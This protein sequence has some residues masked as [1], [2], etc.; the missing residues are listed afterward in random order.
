MKLDFKAFKEEL[1]LHH[2][3]SI[4]YD[5]WKFITKRYFIRYNTSIYH[6]VGYSLD[7]LH[8]VEES[9]SSIDKAILFIDSFIK[10]LKTKKKE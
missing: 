10:K 4:E 2:I 9:S 3:A 6:I 8:V 7:S 1:M 5:R